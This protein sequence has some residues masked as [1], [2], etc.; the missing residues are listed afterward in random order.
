MP[1]FTLP[2]LVDSRAA[3]CY[4]CLYVEADSQF[5]LKQV[6]ITVN[7]LKQLLNL[8]RQFHLK[9]NLMENK[10]FKS[11]RQ[12]SSVFVC[13]YFQKITLT[14]K[15]RLD[16]QQH[17]ISRDFGVFWKACYLGIPGFIFY[18][19]KKM[20]LYLLPFKFTMRQNILVHRWTAISWK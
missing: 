7:I 2:E 17:R 6:L 8:Q 20:A 13:L 15:A 9:Q 4:E 1:F 18:T 3:D 5:L 12:S 11:S 16:W 10:F 19:S 14:L